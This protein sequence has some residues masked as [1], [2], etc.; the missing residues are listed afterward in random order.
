MRFLFTCQPGFG[1]VN[2]MLPLGKA[3]QAAGHEVAIATAHSYKAVV[4][5]HGLR[6]IRAGLEWDESNLEGTLPEIRTIPRGDRT[7]WLFEHVFMDRS[8][9]QMIP[10]LLAA[11]D[12]WSPDAFVISNYDLSG[13]LAA[14]LLELPY[15]TC[16]ISFRW[17]RELIK[18]M[19]GPT[20][21]KL[22]EEFKL[23]PDP[24]CLAYGRYLDVCLMP[25]GWT[26]GRAMA[27]PAY[28]QVVARKLLGSQRNMALKAALLMFVLGLDD[29]RQRRIRQRQPNPR[30]LYVRPGGGAPMAG[31]PAWLAGLPDRPTV[32]VSLGTVF[33]AQYPEVFDNILAG[34]RDEP[35]NLIMTLG[36]NGDP[37][38]FGPQPPNVRIERYIPQSEI[39]PF[40]D[41][42]LNHGGYNTVIEPLLHGIPQ[43]VLPL[44]ADQPV[45]A[46]LCLAHGAAPAL[47]GHVFDLIAGGPGLPVINPS[48]LTPTMIRD[49]VRRALTA[50]QYRAGARALQAKLAALPGLDVAAERLVDLARSHDRDKSRARAGHRSPVHAVPAQ[51]AWQ[52][53]P[54][55]MR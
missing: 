9:R 43:I 15:A 11:A 33:N 53:E 1:H 47:P 39:L 12:M 38:R 29:A 8:P 42:C 13:L 37:A 10:D 2:P 49:V 54:I 51:V 19:C 32:Y 22:R 4:E 24:D 16:N 30:E 45:L 36:A 40:V 7:A 20:L 41:V 23:A 27:Q 6:H 35:I 50:P 46:L 21:A 26:L 34:L 5:S 14:E 28:A 18:L 3:L 48:K 17:P 44:A 31:P 25:D 55:D 52:A